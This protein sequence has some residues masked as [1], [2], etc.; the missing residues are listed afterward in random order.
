MVGSV[1][2]PPIG[3]LQ[4]GVTQRTGEGAKTRPAEQGQ[5]GPNRPAALS[6]PAELT[7]VRE[8]LWRAIE[9]LELSVGAA[10]EASRH[11]QQADADPES[12]SRYQ[13]AIESGIAAG[14]AGLAGMPMQTL[15]DVQGGLIEIEGVDLRLGADRSPAAIET[16]SRRVEDSI[17]RFSAAASRLVAHEQTLLRLESAV[18]GADL[19]ADGARLTALQV[20]QELS[21]GGYA[22]GGSASTSILSLFRS[23]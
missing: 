21:S 23:A 3:A 11:L 6:A 4:S 10:R 1:Q 18:G 12:L 22:L 14:A 8:S 2:S 7:L 5:P 20:R 19:D 9:I 16:L 17:E 13:E 15:A